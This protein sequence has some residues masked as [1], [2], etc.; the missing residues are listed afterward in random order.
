MT[1][2]VGEARD[3]YVLKALADPTRRAILDRLHDGPRTTGTLAAGFET[4]RFAVMKHLSVLERAGLVIVARRGRERW[5]HLNAVPLQRVW[6]R[7]VRPLAADRATKLLTLA[8]RAEGTEPEREMTTNSAPTTGVSFIEVEIEIDAPRERVWR[9]FC[10]QTQ[11]WWHDDFKT[12]PRSRGA[13]LDA[14]LGGHLY[15]DY[16]DGDGLIWMTVTGLKKGERIDLVGHSSA[17]WGGPSTGYHSFTFTE[18][19]DRTRLRLSE[20]YHG[21]VDESG[22]KSLE[23]GWKLLLG[24]GLKSYVE[25][26]DGRSPSTEQG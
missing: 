11:S 4:S 19:G 22:A 10:D 9:A 24:S 12:D 17:E 16:G 8:R 1:E 18:E 5:N 15:E 13:I 14:R 21:K 20:S 6:E 2:L 7:W 25:G 3:A 26:L 23:D